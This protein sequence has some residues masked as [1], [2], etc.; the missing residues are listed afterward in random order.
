M[1][2]RFLS[3]W[4]FINTVYSPLEWVFTP[5]STNW[6]QRRTRQSEIDWLIGPSK[7]FRFGG[8]LDRERVF[9]FSLCRCHF[10][11]YYSCLNSWPCFEG[12]LYCFGRNS[13]SLMGTEGFLG[14]GHIGKHWNSHK[15]P[16]L[17]SLA[18]QNASLLS[19]LFVEKIFSFCLFSQLQKKVEILRFSS[20]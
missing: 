4:L 17:L 20:D 12:N 6:S 19:D 5:D 13:N 9:F 16:A 2:E 11:F 7:I 14:L 18:C 1:K 3:L 15:N 8:F 10:L